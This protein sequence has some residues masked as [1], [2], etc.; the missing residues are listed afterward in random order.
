MVG[1]DNLY[2]SPLIVNPITEFLFVDGGSNRD[3]HG[4]LTLAK[5][6]VEEQ[7]KAATATL[8]LHRLLSLFFCS[9]G[10]ED[11]S[12]DGPQALIH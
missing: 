10:G 5:V 12:N 4:M 7:N 6:R 1:K 2:T 9:D 8:A 11:Q 3:K